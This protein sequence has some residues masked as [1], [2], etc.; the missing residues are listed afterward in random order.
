[1]T[2]FAVMFGIGIA[3]GALS[4]TLGLGGGF[5]MVP[6]LVL[7][8]GLEQHVAQGTSL[9]AMLPISLLGAWSARRRGLVD[10]GRGF[11]LGAIGIVGSVAASQ[12]AVRLVPGS[13][14]KTAFAVVLAFVA[15]RM[16]Y[17]SFVSGRAG[18]ST[19]DGGDPQDPS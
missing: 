16:L 5:L 11:T 2:L 10:V 8:A 1:M 9:L 15:L 18:G 6:A 14:L 4:G 7:V 17:A 13:T 12:I 19:Y 3:V